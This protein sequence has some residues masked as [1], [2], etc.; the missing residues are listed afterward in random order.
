MSG[1]GDKGA[2]QV[3]LADLERLDFAKGDG[4]LPAIVQHA[5]TGAVLMLGYMNRQG[6][7]PAPP[8]RPGGVGGGGEAPPRPPQPP[9]PRLHPRQQN[10]WAAGG[11]PSPPH[12]P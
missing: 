11:S 8:P 12:P 4:L 9:G 6:A 5:V 10:I 3:G 2:A 1:A 7:F